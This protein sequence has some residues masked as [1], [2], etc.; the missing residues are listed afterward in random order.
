[1]AS[2]LSGQSAL[3]GIPADVRPGKGF[4]TNIIKYIVVE[5]P[6]KPSI[7]RWYDFGAPFVFPLNVPYP[8]SDIS[9]MNIHFISLPD[10]KKYILPHLILLYRQ[11]EIIIQV[12]TIMSIQSLSSNGVILATLPV[13]SGGDLTF[14]GPLLRTGDNVVLN[15]IAPPPDE[16]YFLTSTWSPSILNWQQS[17][18]PIPIGGSVLSSADPLVFGTATLISNRSASYNNYVVNVRFEVSVTQFTYSEVP[19]ALCTLAT[20]AGL[21]GSVYGTCALIETGVGSTSTGLAMTDATG[22]VYVQN[23]NSYL[24]TSALTIIINL[25]YL[26]PA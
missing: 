20:S 25:S 5:V 1:M 18:Q 17:A 3:T 19:M 12:K 21:V 24:P 15:V 13:G 14:S 4:G 11:P 26:V 9:A 10:I 23:V 8:L 16:G 22:N 6:S 7:V 2:L